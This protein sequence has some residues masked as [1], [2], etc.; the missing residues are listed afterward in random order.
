M[1][2]VFLGSGVYG[3]PTLEALGPAV[4]AIVTQ[5]DRPA[6]RGGRL[7]PTPVARWAMTHRPEIP[8]IRAPDVNEPELVAELRRLSADVWLVVAFGQK[9]GPAILDHGRVINL[10]ASLLPRWRGAAPVAAA[11]LAGDPVSGNSI[12]RVGARIDAGPVLAQT[13]RDIGPA[14]T[15]GDLERDL[16]A[17]GPALVQQVLGPLVRGE[18]PGEPQDESQATYAPRLHRARDGWVDLTDTAE[19]CR[20]RINALSPWPAA[21]VRLDGRSLKLC[22]AEPGPAQPHPGAP[23]IIVDPE[24]GLIRCGDGRTVRVLEV[25]PEGKR[26]MSWAEY[27]CGHRVSTGAELEHGRAVRGKEG[28]G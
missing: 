13:R 22:R 25:Q 24:L 1:K 6:G 9:L 23:G 16:A 2:L 10:H 26:V 19:T 27:V 28:E 14:T 4:R 17:D 3:L 21:V 20:R 11:I 7:T 18:L 8:L 15:A 12:I 5:P